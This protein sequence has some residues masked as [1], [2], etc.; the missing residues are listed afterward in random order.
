MD[1]NS[2]VKD[3]QSVIEHVLEKIRSKRKIE[4]FDIAILGLLISQRNKA[5]SINILF[6]NSK[7]SEIPI[8]YRT[9]F[10]QE[11][12][13]KFIF[14]K[15]TIERAKV[16]YLHEKYLNVTKTD[17]IIKS[18]GKDSKKALHLKA[19]VDQK[20]KEDN[21]NF[22]NFEELYK[23]RC[24]R[25]EKY[26]KGIE[27]KK[28]RKKSWYSFENKSISN[29]KNLMKS[30]GSGEFYDG[31]YGLSSDAVHGSNAPGILKLV[32]ID[33]E[34]SIG[35]LTESVPIPEWVLENIR[36]A[37]YL[38]LIE[39]IKFYKIDKDKDMRSLKAKIEINTL[40]Q[41]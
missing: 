29:M 21:S 7:Y 27:K 6:E 2:V 28:I 24:E 36:S 14:Q 19:I 26:F 22:N 31:T 3:C 11:M 37:L 4:T 17:N 12:Y 5:D 33:K 9:F 39:F 38:E 25:Y 10:E 18:L 41:H 23:D 20:I 30:L 34:K 13:L 32:D 35:N 16:F 1:L 40:L 15:N 8:L